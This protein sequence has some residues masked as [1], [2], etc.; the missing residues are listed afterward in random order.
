M[1]SITKQR[2][3]RFMLIPC[4]CQNCG[5]DMWWHHYIVYMEWES[6]EPWHRK[7]IVRWHVCEECYD[8]YADYYKNKYSVYLEINRNGKML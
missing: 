2:A 8:E 1:D 7:T 5:K 3:R 4:A 6:K